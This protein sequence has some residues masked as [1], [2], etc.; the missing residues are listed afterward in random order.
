MHEAYSSAVAMHSARRGTNEAPD[1]LQRAPH[2]FVND[3]LSRPGCL[4][5]HSK[6]G[7]ATG[8]LVIANVDQE[9]KGEIYAEFAASNCRFL[10]EIQ[11]AGD[12]HKLG[13]QLASR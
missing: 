10:H 11:A 2:L 6:R 8:R 12:R 7:R 1:L 4:P 9:L 13:Q 5:C 3:F